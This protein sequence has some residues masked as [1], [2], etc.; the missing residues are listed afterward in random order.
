MEVIMVENIKS[1]LSVNNKINWGYYRGY[2]G[3]YYS[4]PFRG[5]LFII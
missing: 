1:L 5:L 2:Y 3:V 4:V